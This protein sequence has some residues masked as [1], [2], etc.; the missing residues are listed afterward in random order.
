MRENIFRVLAHQTFEFL[1]SKTKNISFCTSEYA[2]ALLFFIFPFLGTGRGARAVKWSL[3]WTPPPRCG[4]QLV[5]IGPRCFFSLGLGGI[6]NFCE[7][8]QTAFRHTDTCYAYIDLHRFYITSN[9]TC[10]TKW[11][12]FFRLKGSLLTG[13]F[14]WLRFFHLTSIQRTEKKPGP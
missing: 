9:R 8:S 4:K 12:V 13:C 7:F 5:Q 14:K 6:S 3:W 11:F 2:Q 10:C 1:E